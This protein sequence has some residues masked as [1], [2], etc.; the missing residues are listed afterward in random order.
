MTD[1]FLGPPSLSFPM[2]KLHPPSPHLHVHWWDTDPVVGIQ[3][4]TL[5][6]QGVHLLGGRREGWGS[7]CHLLCQAHPPALPQV[8]KSGAHGPALAVWSW[9]AHLTSLC[10]SL[11][12]Y[13]K[14]TKISEAH[15]RRGWEEDLGKGQPLAVEFAK[16]TLTIPGQA[17][18]RP[19]EVQASW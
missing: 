17:V 18:G 2:G 7:D 9:E 8:P 6:M 4:S 15:F 11:F 14:G 19:S 1:C 5:S 10:L 12:I 13:Q 16:K 3:L